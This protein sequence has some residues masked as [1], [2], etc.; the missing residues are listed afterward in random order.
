MRAT[1]Y[2]RYST[3]KQRETSIADQLR[4]AHARCE[5]E[6]WPVVA[7][8]ADEGISGATPV[9]LR[10]G[11]KAL[12][13]DALAKR[14]D[15]LVVEG[16]DRLSRELGEA[17]QL[18]K[19]LE[20]RGIRIIGTS[21]GYDTEAKG[22]KV[23]RIARGLV[24]EL[25]L[26]DLREKTHR[27]LAG[28]FDRGFHVGGRSYG[29]RSVDVAGGKHL[30]VDETQAAVV[31][32]I[33]A[34][35]AD[36]ETTRAIVHSFNAR[37][38]PGPRG[39][40]WACS[41][42]HVS[43]TRGL[44]L[45]HNE[46]YVGREVWNRRQWL[47]DPDT[48]KRRYVDRPASEWQTRQVPELQIVDDLTWQRTRARIAAGAGLRGR[49]G[50]GASPRTLLGGLLRCA[51][52]SG[53]MTAV[54]ARMYGCHARKDR[55]PSECEGVLVRRAD[56]ERR[57]IAEL[58]TELLA[59]EAMAEMHAAVRHQVA[60]HQRATQG[61][62]GAATKRLPALQAEISRLADA[63]ATMGLSAALQA[64]LAAAETERELIE[65][66]LKSAPSKSPDAAK[67]VNDV[68]TRWRRLVLD[69]RTA[70]D[71]EADRD[72][73]RQILADLLGTVT[74]GRDAATGEAW[75][76]LEEPAER[77]LLAAA[78]VLPG[79]VAGARNTSRRRIWFS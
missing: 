17:E 35:Y 47:K 74:V 37:G 32:E 65:Q 71:E 61:S 1:L 30:A 9:A 40:A 16:L 2:A 26:D 3:D 49:V 63:V 11:G 27:G 23:M 7:T 58:R 59:P 36:G 56:L 28:Q 29:Y 53:P 70:L 6:G 25:Y 8:H 68:A 31:R 72:R 14:F 48:G 22:R 51:R 45:L 67:L 5:R 38:L 33:Y 78:G 12:L 77:L 21:D 54:D 34:R 18:V 62:A 75:A 42:L 79:V 52:C 41:A 55:G 39:G 24:N 20:H 43:H 13:A 69:L 60:E 57:L 44:G 50:R 10:P 19:R 4:G 64:R 73:T 76:D 46:L 15:I 66:Q